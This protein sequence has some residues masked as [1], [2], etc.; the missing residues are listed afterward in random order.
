MQNTIEL[1]V[2]YYETDGQ[3]VVHH[4][5]YF[6]YFE[7]ARVEMLKAMGHDYAD[8][9]RDGVFLVV[10]SVGC[11]FMRP[12]RFGDTLRIVTE[13]VKATMARIEHR[14]DVFVGSYQVAQ[15]QSVIACIDRDGNIRRMPECLA[16]EE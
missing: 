9:E 4:A 14:Y 12:A 15:G 8:L 16:P 11:K 1:D 3:G 10:H 2:R 13:V 7:V 5:N 6:K